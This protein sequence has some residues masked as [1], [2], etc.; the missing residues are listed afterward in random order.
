MEPS[1]ESQQEPEKTLVSKTHILKATLY[2][3]YTMYLNMK[4]CVSIAKEKGT[5]KIRW[6]HLLHF[7][8]LFINIII[9]C[10]GLQL[11]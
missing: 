4:D 8:T 10:M 6:I 3:R 9:V 11:V 5:Q 7:L 2:H 1:S